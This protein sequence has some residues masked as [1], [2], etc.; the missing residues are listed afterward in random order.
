MS[1]FIK[2][3]AEAKL[4][5]YIAVGSVVLVLVSMAVLVF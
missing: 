2:L 1:E 5:F 3:Q 4:A